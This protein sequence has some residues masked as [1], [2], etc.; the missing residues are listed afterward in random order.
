MRRIR[1]LLLNCW[2]T[3][4]AS[5]YNYYFST[6]AKAE[7]EADEKKDCANYDTDECR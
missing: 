4:V 1:K 7:Y 6:P 5:L 3:T 2:F